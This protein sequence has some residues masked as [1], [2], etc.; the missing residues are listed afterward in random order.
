MTILPP[1]NGHRERTTE[2]PERS[3]DSTQPPA[4]LGPAGVALRL[5]A[6]E[7]QVSD[8]HLETAGVSKAL[9]DIRN[10]VVALRDALDRISVDIRILRHDAQQQ[11]SDRVAMR[12]EVD[13][14]ATRVEEIA[15]E[16]A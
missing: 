8:I 11:R 2:P 12:T 15:K 14:L 3:T 6:L 1:P 10:A 13:K 4:D 16:S 7:E 5:L 9:H